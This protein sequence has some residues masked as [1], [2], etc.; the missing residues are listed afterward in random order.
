MALAALYHRQAVKPN[1]QTVMKPTRFRHE[2]ITCHGV[3]TTVTKSDI[4]L[5]SPIASGVQ[6][7]TAK[8]GIFVSGYGANAGTARSTISVRGVKWAGIRCRAIWRPM[9][10]LRHSTACR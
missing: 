10:S 3:V 8:P 5:F 7:V 4:N 9:A 1:L 2:T 6:A